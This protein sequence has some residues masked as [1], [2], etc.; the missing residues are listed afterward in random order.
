MTHHY[1]PFAS[2][3]TD[4]PL[5]NDLYPEA[6]GSRITLQSLR[7]APRSDLPRTKLWI[8][9]EVDGLHFPEVFS[10]TKKGYE[11]YRTYIEQFQNARRL[12]ETPD[13]G[14]IAVFVNAVLD[15]IMQTADGMSNLGYVSVPQLPYIPGSSRNKI[16]RL[17]AE[18]SLKWKSVQ[19][20]PPR[21]ILPVIFAKKW[22]QTDSKTERNTKV[23]LAC[24]CFEA[25]GAD[26]MWV[27]D[28]TL[29]DH[30]AVGTLENQRFPGIIHFH[31]EINAKLPA[32]AVT[33]AGPYWGLNLVLWTRGL[34]RFPGIGVGRGYQYF[35]PGRD[36]QSKAAKTRVA[37]PPLKRLAVSTAVKPWL[38]SALRRLN[39]DDPA[40]SELAKLAKSLGFL[41]KEKARQRVAE[42]YRNWLVKLESVPASSRALTLYQDLSSAFVLG[43]R[44]ESFD[45]NTEDV[46]NPAIIAKQLMVNCL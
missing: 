17:L 3:K 6:A 40:Y 39:S 28:S 10:A 21:L 36:P 20:R 45:K 31:E 5:V 41:T 11:K 46:P 18:L 35:L 32:D 12:L 38:Q 33:I 37:I 2:Y 24:A 1:I 14:S 8:D 4:W 26:G 7:S 42:F 23:R 9:A 25:S 15:S 30:A 16:N 43:S 44:L 22:G 29:D 34:V 19:R 13:S 27:V